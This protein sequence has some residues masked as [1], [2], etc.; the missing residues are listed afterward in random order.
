MINKIMEFS[1][2]LA[3]L[4]ITTML[5]YS[6][7]G[8]DAKKPPISIMLE[9]IRGKK[10]YRLESKVV[11]SE[12]LL[13]ALN[14]LILARGS[15]ASVIV[16]VHESTSIADLKNLRGI[17]EK[18]GFSNI[19]YFHFADAKEKMAEIIMVRPAVPFSL[20]P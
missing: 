14:P 13:G 2:R 7:I 3:L 5:C 17:I 19:K 15:E 1:I 16:L 8:A 4:F 10:V 18:A 20:S 11:S 6:A 9:P 12:N